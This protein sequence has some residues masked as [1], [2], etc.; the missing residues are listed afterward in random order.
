[1]GR[2]SNQSE[3]IAV[4]RNLLSIEPSRPL[5]DSPRLP[6]QVQHRLRADEQ[7]ELLER[8][9]AGER[10]HL[11]CED[12]GIHRSTLDGLL[13]NTG[14]RRP[15]SM[16]AAETAEAIGLYADGWSCDRIGQHLGRN[17]G[18]IWLALRSA[19]VQLRRPWEHLEAKVSTGSGLEGSS[20]ETPGEGLCGERR[21]QANDQAS[22]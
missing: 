11:L 17:H 4:V 20:R 21:E 13:R 18:T 5:A 2:Y 8:Y 6:R 3:A 16:T 9:L 15:R 14:L 10:A 19:G 7:A 1:M 22:D 12:Y